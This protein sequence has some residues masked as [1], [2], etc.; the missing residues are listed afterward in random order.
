MFTDVQSGRWQWIRWVSRD[1]ACDIRLRAERRGGE[2]FKE[3]ARATPQ[4]ANLDGR[5]GKNR[6]TAADTVPEQSPYAEAIEHA[7]L[8]RQRAHR[9]E[10][11]ANIPKAEFDAA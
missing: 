7:G 3:L 5:A 4:T 10:S 6:V 8:T 2:L 11:L 9:M 1:M